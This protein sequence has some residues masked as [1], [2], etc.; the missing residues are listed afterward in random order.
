MSLL[1]GWKLHPLQNNKK[2]IAIWPN[3]TFIHFS[4]HDPNLC[5]VPN[6]TPSLE[7]PAC[8]RL[9]DQSL[10]V[11]DPLQLPPQSIPIAL[12]AF[13]WPLIQN[14]AQRCGA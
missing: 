10:S 3:M 13:Q 7:S 11:P 14:Q 2:R 4:H 8:G 1:D 6:P 9:K 5:P 12:N